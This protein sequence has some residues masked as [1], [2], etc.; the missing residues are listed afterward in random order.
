MQV[1]TIGFN[2]EKSNDAELEIFDLETL[3]QRDVSAHS[4]QNPHRITFFM[5]VFIERG[6]GV[7]MVDFKSY[8]FE[9]GSII[10]VRREQVHAFDFSGNPAGKVIIFTQAFL[11]QVHAN[12]RLPNYTPTHLNQARS[13]VLLLDESSCQSAKSMI[14]EVLKEVSR[15]RRDPLIV[16]YLFCSFSLMLHRLRPEERHDLLSQE[17]SVKL[18]NFFDL[19][20]VNY[21]RIRD[22]NWYATQ[23]GTTYKTLNIICKLATD[24]TAK[25]MIDAFVTIEMKRRLVVGRV[26][27]QQIAFDFGF[28]DASNFVK[29]FKNQTQM[30]PSQFQKQFENVQL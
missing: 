4:P 27:T 12:M 24:L 3:A 25:Q 29:Y 21:E 7:H 5:M 15:E 14:E 13:P 10:F 20:Q 8:P 9:S 2:Y 1:P 18:A 28:E 22:A 23:I 19:L 6:Q 26:A 11:D 16:M 30:T 17:Q